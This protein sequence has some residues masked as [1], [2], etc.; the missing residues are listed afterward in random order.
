MSDLKLWG[1]PVTHKFAEAL[2]KNQW[3]RLDESNPGKPDSEYRDYYR[4][5]RSAMPQ[6]IRDAE[7]GYQEPQTEG[8]KFRY[9]IEKFLRRNR[10]RFANDAEAMKFFDTI[11][12]SYYNLTPRKDEKTS[13]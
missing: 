8:E 5:K 4:E 13:L 3:D 2:K 1:I 9:E 7:M 11:E 6:A 10:D 12:N